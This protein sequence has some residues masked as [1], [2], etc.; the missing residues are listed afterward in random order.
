MSVL[1]ICVSREHHNTQRLAA[2]IA[3]ELEAEV[4]EPREAT[5]ELIA[6]HDLIGFGSGIRFGRHYA[7]LMR[8]VERLPRQDVKRAFVFS[9]SGVGTLLWQQGSDYFTGS[10][11]CHIEVVAVAAHAEGRGIGSALMQAVET[12]VAQSGVATISLS[13][14]EGNR[15]ARALYAGW[16]RPQSCR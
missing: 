2:A 1:V 14:F 11:N 16:Q 15:R 13:V 8:M 10:P 9:T 5:P 7:E 12:H 6:E 3:D 4:V